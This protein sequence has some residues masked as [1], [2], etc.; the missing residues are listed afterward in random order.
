MCGAQDQENGIAAW[1]TVERKPSALS[2][3]HN[4]D[5]VFQ[6]KL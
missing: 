1:F 4:L 6:S 5:M 3:L 2:L